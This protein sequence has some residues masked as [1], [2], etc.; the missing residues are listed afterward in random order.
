MR[1]TSRGVRT[2][3]LEVSGEAVHVLV[4]RQH[5]VGL[6]LE[7][8]DVP[9]TQNSQQNRDV[10]I[11]RGAA[12]MVVLETRGG[13]GGGVS[14][15]RANSQSGSRTDTTVLLPSNELLPEASQSS[16]SLKHKQVRSGS[17]PDSLETALVSQ[18]V[19]VPGS[20]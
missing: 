14:L 8:V 16:R 2:H 19:L 11:Q 15:Q 17:E 13:G 9:D 3:L 1:G 18:P 6:G 4:V 7:E 10:L 20:V 12:E 5:G